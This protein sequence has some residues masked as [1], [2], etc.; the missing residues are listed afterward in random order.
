VGALLLRA[1]YPQV[2]NRQC[3]ARRLRV[4]PLLVYTSC[5]HVEYIH[6]IQQTVKSSITHRQW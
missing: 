5:R 6:T 3:C 1:P 4:P 2:S